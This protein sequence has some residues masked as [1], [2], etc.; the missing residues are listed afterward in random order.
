MT[1]I[2]SLKLTNFLLG[3]SKEANKLFRESYTNF[4]KFVRF[5]FSI[6]YTEKKV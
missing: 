1:N 5:A 4:N 2:V 3:K 6:I